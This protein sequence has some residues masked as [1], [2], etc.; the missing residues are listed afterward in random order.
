MTYVPYGTVPIKYVCVEYPHLF[1]STHVLTVRYIR[2]REVIE[3][4]KKKDSLPYGTVQL[5]VQQAVQ[6][7][8]LDTVRTGTVPTYVRTSV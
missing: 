3:N 2:I 1:I 5:L 7:R 4:I 8:L 6:H